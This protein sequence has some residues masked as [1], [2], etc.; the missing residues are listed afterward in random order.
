MSGTL[1]QMEKESLEMAQNAPP[2][3][4]TWSPPSWRLPAWSNSRRLHNERQAAEFL[5]AKEIVRVDHINSKY[6]GIKARP[7]LWPPLDV[8]YLKLRNPSDLMALLEDHLHNEDESDLTFT[9]RKLPK[10]V[11]TGTGRPHQPRMHR[12]SPRREAPAAQPRPADA[13]S[14]R[15]EA[16]AAQPGPADAEVEDRGFDGVGSGHHHGETVVDGA[17]TGVSDDDDDN[18]DDDD[19][20]DDDERSDDEFE[21]KRRVL[22]MDG[23]RCEPVNEQQWWV[24]AAEGATTSGTKGASGAKGAV[25][26]GAAEPSRGDELVEDEG[27]RAQASF[28]T[29]AVHANNN[30]LS[31]IDQLPAVLCK[32][33]VDRRALSVLDLS[34]N[35]IA[36]IPE[37]MSALPSLE[38]L[39]LHS[40]ALATF[41]ELTNLQVIANPTPNLSPKHTA[42]KRLPACMP[43][44]PSRASDVLSADV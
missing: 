15:R 5:S 23:R 12:R 2:P 38:V 8:S 29:L 32:V 4:L 9:R 21:V 22:Q 7:S 33:L 44:S 20:D 30:M 35:Q 43:P 17:D 19:D 1:A 10:L 13:R 28:Q 3:I 6:V 42:L 34:F 31:S 18:D 36:H 24:V 40:N 41:E 25:A 26:S 16:P 11:S 14:P 27:S 37:A 39:R